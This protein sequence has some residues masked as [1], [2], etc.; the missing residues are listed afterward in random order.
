MLTPLYTSTPL[1]KNFPRVLMEAKDVEEL[2]ELLE[3]VSEGKRVW[4]AT[5]DAIVDPVLIVSPDFIVKRSN[6]AAARSAKNA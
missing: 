4:E 1:Q 2:K 3:V 5:F 6:L